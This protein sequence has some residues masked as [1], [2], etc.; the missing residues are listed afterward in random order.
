MA[1]QKKNKLVLPPRYA[2]GDPRNKARIAAGA[3]LGRKMLG[4]DH[5]VRKLRKRNG[6]YMVSIPK[7]LVAEFEWKVGDDIAFT[8]IEVPGLMVICAIKR[9]EDPA[10]TPAAG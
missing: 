1:T 8:K 2:T 7:W 9:P 3:K 5:P 10:G 6:S 4:Y